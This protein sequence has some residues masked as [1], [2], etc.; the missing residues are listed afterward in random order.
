MH[1]LIFLYLLNLQFYEGAKVEGHDQ[2]PSLA[3]LGRYFEQ[4]EKNNDAAQRCFKK[5][6]A[7]DPNVDIAGNRRTSLES[8]GQ[9]E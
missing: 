6:L 2:A 1:S 4:V 3:A 9:E 8:V 7:I 5:A